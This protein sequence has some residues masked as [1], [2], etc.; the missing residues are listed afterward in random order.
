MVQRR[1]GGCARRGR[2]YERQPL[3][4]APAFTTALVFL[5]LLYSEPENA[6][7]RFNERV[8]ETILG[9]GLAYLY[10][11][12]LPKLIGR[13]QNGGRGTGW[14]PRRRSSGPAD[15]GRRG[16][17]A[18]YYLA[19]AGSFAQRSRRVS[20]MR[21]SAPGRSVRSPGVDAEVARLRVGDDL[22]RIVARGSDAADELVEAELLGS[23]DL[24][25]AV[26]RRPTAT[27]PTALATSSA[28]MG[29]ISAGGSRTVLPSV[30][31]SAMPLDEL[32]ELRRV[33][34]RVRDRGVLDQLLLGEL[35]AEV[36]A[37]GQAV[38]ADDRQRD[39]MSHARGRL[40]GEQVARSTS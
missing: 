3:V 40:R 17:S 15:R 12:A 13:W 28:A 11:L 22:A 32:E 34:D 27:R 19:P 36:A 14:V 2:R 37:L 20:P 24:D 8:L 25:D 21:A 1:G 18:T 23:G 26:Q 7:H 31:A 29:W 9:V 35:R 39:V 30:A 38:G 10:G 5:L 33:D 16:H 6:A 4:C